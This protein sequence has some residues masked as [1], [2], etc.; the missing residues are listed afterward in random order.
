LGVCCLELPANSWLREFSLAKELRHRQG[1]FFTVWWSC[2]HGGKRSKCSAL[3]HNC[4]ALQPAR[5]QSY[6]PGH[7][8]LLEYRVLEL[9]GEGLSFGTAEEAGYPAGFCH[10]YAEVV[11]AS[12]RIWM[13]SE[14]PRVPSYSLEWLQTALAQS[15][16]RLRDA[17]VQVKVVSRLIAMLNGIVLGDG[18]SIFS[19]WLVWLFSRSLKCACKRRKSWRAPNRRFLTLPL[20]GTGP[21]CRHTR[22]RP[23]TASTS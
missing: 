4:P 14:L 1:V 19:A 22:G 23:S 2:C 3:L 5:H 12:L 6:Y 8:G 13:Q 15:T 16:A 11:A 17:G 10:V 9:P 21:L 18:Y 20:H 7:E